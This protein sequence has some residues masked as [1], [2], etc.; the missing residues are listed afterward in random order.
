[1][2]SKA[3]LTKYLASLLLLFVSSLAY[4]QCAPFMQ[5]NGGTTG[6][7]GT[8]CVGE[9]IN[10]EANS[11]G[12]TTTILWDFGNTDQSTDQKPT[13]AF[14]AAGS[15]TITFTGT[16]AGGTCTE[17]L[18]VVIKPSPVVGF[19]L[20]NSNIQ[21]FR[22]NEFCFKD[23]SNAPDGSIIRET[24]LISDGTRYD[25]TYALPGKGKDPIDWELCHTIKDPSGGWFDVVV[26]SEDSSGCI[27]RIEYKDV[28]FVH[29]DI[30]VS[31]DNITPAPNPG[32]D[33]TL[34]I[35]KNT[36]KVPLADIDT[37][38]WAFGDGVFEGGNSTVNTD[39][40]HG[41]DND[42]IIRHMYNT[43]GSFD[44]SLIVEAYGCT[45]V[46]T[47]KAAVGNI[48]MEP[49]IISTPNPACTPDNPIEFSVDNLP[50]TPGVDAFLWNFGDPPSGPNNTNDK[51]L[52][53][54]K[55][56]GP[57]PWMISLRLIAGPCD[58]TIYDTVQIIG[59]GST[60]EVAFDRVPED[61][62]YQCV[63]EDSVHFPNNSSYYQNDWNRLDEDS[64]TFYYDY[65]FDYVYDNTTGLYS[66]HFRKWEE[67]PR[68]NF[69][70]SDSTY[71]SATDTIRELGYTVY[72]D[73]AKDSL[74]SIRLGDTTWY[75]TPFGNA[76]QN[77]FRFGINP[78]KRFV[79]N[80]TPPVGKGG[81]GI[82][83]Q[84]AIDP[85]VNIRGYNPNVWRVWEMGDRFAPQ[86]TTDSRPWMNK[87][88]GINCNWTID[89]T[90][91]H[92]YTPWDEIY[93]TFQDGRNYQTPFTET[94]LFKPGPYCYQ[95]NIFPDD[96]MITRQN[97]VLTVPHTDSLYKYFYNSVG[98][99][100]VFQDSIIITTLPNSNEAFYVSND[101][102]GFNGGT[103]YFTGETINLYI[104]P[105]TSFF[106][107]NGAAD[108][109]YFP[110][111]DLTI[112]RPAGKIIGT[113]LYWD[114]AKDTFVAVNNLTD[115]TYHNENWLGKNTPVNGNAKTTWTVTNYDMDFFIPAG[116]TITTLKLPA[117]GGGGANVG[118]VRTFTGPATVTL[119]A[120]EQFE[121]SSNDS[122]FSV[123]KVESTPADTTY[124]QPSTYPTQ[125]LQ[126]G[127]LVTVNETAIF[128]DSAKHREEW[129]IDNA[130]C[131]N[132]SLWQKD[133]IHPL[134][135]EATGTKSLA[136]IPPNA[137]GLR[138]LTG[139]PCPFD[140]NNL[141]YVL[142]FD[143]TET[144]PGCSQRWFAANLD[145]LSGTNNFIPFDGGL[146]APPPPGLPI[147]FVL[148]YDI[149]GNL[150][151]QFVKG[152]TPGEIG[153]DPAQR[154]DGSFTLGLIVGNGKMVATPPG[155]TTMLPECLDTFWY[156]DL[157]RILYL[158]SGFTILEP[159]TEKKV[160]CA[161]GDAYFQINEPI[162]DSI[163]VLRWA[164]GYQ[165]IGKGPDLDIYVEQFEYYKEYT[166]PV[167]G[168]N[169]K[170]IVYNGE[171]W[172]YNYVIRQQITDFGGYETIDT[173]VTAIVKDWRIV[174]NTRNAD[175]AVERIFE[176]LG[177][178]Y[179]ELPEDEIPLYLGDGTFGCIDTTGLSQLFQFNKKAYSEK[180]DADVW[181]DGDKRMRCTVYDPLYVFD[182]TFTPSILTGADSLVSVDSSFNRNREDCISSYEVA[183]ILHFRDSSLRGY[184]TLLQDTSGNG[185]LDTIT[186]VWKK[187]Y[188]FPE[189]VTPDPCYPGIKDTI[190]R[191][192]NGPMVPTLFVNN[193]VGCESRSAQ[194]L[195][196]GFYNDY[197]MENENLCQGLTL[198]IEDSLRYYQYG[199]ED[200][201]TYP[202]KEIAFWQD[203]IRYSNNVEYHEVDWDSTDGVWD[204]ERTIIVNHKYP[205]PGKYHITIVAKDSIGC[206]DTSHLTA[207]VSKLNPDF[208][209][210]SAILDCEAIVN[211]TDSS[212]FIDPCAD[213]CLDGT[214]LRCESI[215]DWLWD[216]GDG[217]RKSLLQNP[218]HN[219]T[220]G[221]FFDVKLTVWT[222]LGC[223]D[224]ITKRI[225]IPGPQPEFKF[226]FP[227]WIDT[228]TIC[229]GDS[230]FLINE[231]KGELTDP[232]FS[233]DWG[234]GNFDPIPSVGS[235]FG[236]Q[237]NT[238]DTFEL[239]L[240]QQDKMP[241]GNLCT[242]VFPD[243]SDQILNRRKI[244][245]IVHPRPEVG[246]TPKESTICPNEQITFT[247]STLDDRYSRLKWH[248]GDAN[249]NILSRTVPDL[250]ITY[251]YGLPGTY[252]VILAPEYDELPR[253]WA[254]DTV[255]VTVAEVIA[256]FDIDS[257]LS[258]EFCFTNTSTGAD[259]TKYVWSF[260]DDP[261][262]GSSNEVD[263]CYNW[264][265]RIGQWEVCLIAESSIGC[266]DTI[267]K[268]INNRFARKII[269]YNV[270]TPN[271]DS[272]NDEFLIDGDGIEEYGI[273]IFNR[274]G[275]RI[276]ESTDITQSWNGK[277]DNTGATCPEGT[278]FYIIN[279]KFIFGEENE[280]LGPIEGQVELIRN[281]Q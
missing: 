103:W 28:F 239:Y 16:G 228:A 174:A 27:T 183:H 236:H 246:I 9:L 172:L 234:D 4:S 10:F 187:S 108:T 2:F 190:Y 132:V 126:F 58:I 135:C 215:T 244:I 226:E 208:T 121:V 145:S 63:I 227:V 256:D 186:G 204:G 152:Y 56:Y 150:G 139:I 81:T 99:G 233:M 141:N 155:S 273:K 270:F 271:N 278:Y 255:T 80:Y 157:F 12:F 74:A 59:P 206:R 73:A 166:G 192:G 248:M 178:Y 164:W 245:V 41:K 202:I 55:A 15:Y 250:T 277:V 110:P 85:A 47:W 200:P 77:S 107:T 5:L 111:F 3:I 8:F 61:E 95:V 140:G 79:F 39:W 180:V 182:S 221:G 94:R 232:K 31:F 133:T 1:M 109:T 197:W 160:I 70:V 198:F 129:F 207:Y 112:R 175:K 272:Q 276:Y 161:G 102:N 203:P 211:F 165:G 83:D 37:F 13:Y 265:D 258:P 44:G 49:N 159:A 29:P 96:T 62:T 137:K 146:L 72:Y 149:R 122:I 194:L 267:C 92:W 213:T 57:G 60:I 97:L 125:K 168:R 241:D 280:G 274:W 237:Y 48:V 269:P 25:T 17:N 86:C 91:V 50:S 124:A 43:H 196:V 223:I 88:V 156:N 205:D 210:P 144:K 257:I 18:N 106:D 128:V 266:K 193:T 82:G 158:N 22:N 46:F 212:W 51:T 143:I 113:E 254:R 78:R 229:V 279:Y 14:T 117:P 222:E 225:F 209:F 219:Y 235:R 176:G 101:R 188:V 185:Q 114:A 131:H 84:T 123:A 169:D 36:S 67:R 30:G 179:Q 281:E 71:S 199:E 147:P 87:N 68:G 45:D 242:R 11:P 243:T 224:S 53:P 65:T 20:L 162:Q 136:L 104:D 252:S 127:I 220:S 151:G 238:A 32:C 89:S 218:S 19:E 134:K 264:D 247:A 26:E 42:F 138:W 189:E 115:T 163:A 167:A 21:C 6:T 34:G 118:R 195:N 35:F 262:D 173:I 23:T 217:T 75:K 253:C 251:S 130:Q 100:N 240:W 52:V 120:D 54:T 230:V 38:Y 216:F 231:S 171:D 33:S 66:F 24:F 184:D 7:T 260:E 76:P 105:D 90:P 154:P 98:P 181:V 170:D 153:S 69:L 177:L 263:P 142:T 148:P 259:S 214:I 191:A 119:E 249:N 40:W 64:I 268:P 275:E 93:R 201:F 116:V 261:L